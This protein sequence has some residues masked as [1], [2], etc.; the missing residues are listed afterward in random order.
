[1]ILPR[2]EFLNLLGIAAGA[3]GMGA[4]TGVWAIPDDRVALA[5]RGPGL[6]SQAPSIC[7]LCSGGCGLSV[8]LVDGLPVGL[9]G[10]PTHPLNQGGA[11]PVGLSALD[12][13]YSPTRL[14]SPL[15]RGAD[16]TYE[17]VDW[18]SALSQIAGKL[19]QLR[20]A[21]QADRVAFVTGTS[22]LLLQELVAHFM[23]A[24]GSPHVAFADPNQN[25]LPFRLSHGS[26]EVPGFD[27][28]NCDLVLSFGL[29]LF[30]D[31]PSPLFAIS[32]LIGSRPTEEIATTLHVGSRLSPSASKAE[33]FVRIRP[34]THGA[35]ALGVA[36]VL[37]REGLFDRPFVAEHTLGF[38]D[39]EREGLEFP[40]FRR[41]L[42][43]NYYPDRVA[44]ICS[45]EAADIFRV[46]RRFGQASSPLALFGGEAAAGSNST[47]TG[48]AV[49]SLNALMG[50]MNR[51][52]GVTPSPALP[53]SPLPEL[54]GGSPDPG[55]SLFRREGGAALFGR[56]PIEGLAQGVLDDSQP[57]EVLFLHGLNPLHDSP[58]LGLLREAMER[59]PLVV[60]LGSFQDDTAGASHLILPE[61]VFLEAWQEQ[62]TPPGN[63]L[64][65]LGL[66]KPV[67]EP[68]HD[69]RHAGDV[70]LALQQL[71]GLGERGEFPWEDYSSYLQAR[72]A[73]LAMSGEGA[74]I[75]GSFD[76]NWKHFLEERGWRFSQHKNPE[77]FWKELVSRS[78]WASSA[79]ALTNWKRF[80]PGASGRYE[81]FSQLL[82][83]ELVEEGRSEEPG[84]SALE[85]LARGARKFKFS[86]EG[87]EVC[88]PHFEPPGQRGEGELDLVLFRP[89]TARGAVA[90][91][92]R[93]VLEMF[94]YRVLSGWT[95][96]AEVHPETA[97]R[98]NIGD[99]DRV[100]VES[101][102]GRIE[103]VVHLHPGAAADTI[104]V[105]VGLGH[106]ASFV[107]EVVGS[108]PVS[109][110][111]VVPDSL[112]GSLAL[113]ATRVRLKLVRR[114]PHGGPSQPYEGV[115]A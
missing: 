68:L 110:L 54:S 39:W 65:V 113:N 43:E 71:A 111:E 59:I 41:F 98:L 29:D 49:H 40:G 16:G 11:C 22:G 17:Q 72:V 70:L 85:A 2:R 20:A 96:W 76:E 102:K 93:T 97:R 69:T 38:E 6:E 36:Q 8:R 92:S 53:L 3:A 34:G 25:P 4:C 13:L 101:D 21:D 86:L 105:P 1:M 64:G 28:A 91:A 19:S 15:K 84:S 60:H 87:L 24:L 55:R 12:I 100:A 7:S 78:G 74:V 32:A 62:T 27:I 82:F 52:G 95:T 37:V 30:E 99:G 44:Q 63:S 67:L 33:R 5:L 103:V 57:I 80:F 90:T 81:F 77:D 47:W 112:S 35:F 14:Q 10:N 83:K 56:D 9:K 109:L 45:C 51:P 94:G 31:G 107:G 75:T 23:A 89:I 115:S 61:P 79:L 50:S 114:R 58:A 46:A 66:S 106:P 18:D 108:N 42:L 26:S 48:L 73:G 88:L 104:H